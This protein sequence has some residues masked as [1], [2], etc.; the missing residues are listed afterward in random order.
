MKRILAVFLALLM[1]VTVVGCG[2]KK[3]QPIQLTLSTEDSEAILRAAGITLPD[4]ENA[5]GAGSHVK[6]YSWYDPL[7]NYNEDEI[8]N[9]GNWTFK[10][11]YNGTVEWVECVYENYY[12]D[13]ANY[14]TAG[15]PPDATQATS[16]V[17]ALYPMNC[18]K[19]M[20][21][22]VDPYVDL[23]DP[24]WV[25]MKEFAD[26]F[27]LGGQHYHMVTDVSF[28]NVVCY[29]RRVMN[30]WGFDDPADLYYND[31]WTWDVFYDMCMDFSDGDE[32]RYALDGYAYAGGLM[33]STGQQLFGLNDEGI[34]VGNIDSPEIERSQQLVYDLV[35]NGCTYQNGGWA[36]RGDGFG[37][38]MSDGKCLFYIIA[39]WAF[40]G[41]V[42]EITPI[43]GD[44][45]QNEVMFAPLPRDPQGDGIYYLHSGISGYSIIKGSFNPEGVALLASCE[46]FKI[47]DPTVVNIDKKQLREIYLWN[48]EML[49]MYDECYELA[50]AHPMMNLTNN[51]P[52]NLGNAIAGLQNGTIHGGSEPS[53]WAQLKEKYGEQIEYYIEEL[54]QTIADFNASQS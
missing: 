27:M 54:N 17:M 24:L 44:V 51:L 13:L 4:A 52:D 37:N 39:T 28:D 43:W 29:N 45:S 30:E 47:I 33:E 12:D 23:E 25:G 42:E 22:P 36:L 3:R 26:K 6:W 31:E 35:K 34:F 21:Q 46:R 38:G 40:T 50:A 16:G 1:I 53:S 20:I 11:K 2:K 48:D 8:V 5:P 14:L 15:T 7:E 32:D 19:G 41:R 18:I 49:D 9:T 10:N